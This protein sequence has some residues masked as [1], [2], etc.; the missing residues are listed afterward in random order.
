MRATV[1]VNYID[2]FTDELHEAGSSVELA[3]ER[4]EELRAGGYV[5]L[6]AAKA[7]PRKRAAK[8]PAATKAKAAE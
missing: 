4:A 7:S 8:K 5:E 1:I 2:K 3:E 6:E